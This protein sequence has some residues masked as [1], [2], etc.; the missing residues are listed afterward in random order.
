MCEALSTWPC[1]SASGCHKCGYEKLKRM[2]VCDLALIALGAK[3]QI[4][5]MSDWLEPKTIDLS[6]IQPCT[7]N[8]TQ[9]YR[10]MAGSWIMKDLA[11]QGRSRKWPN[12]GED[13]TKVKKPSTRWLRT[14]HMNTKEEEEEWREPRGN[15]FK[16]FSVQCVCSLAYR[17]SLARSF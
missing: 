3:H 1:T 9:I 14:L 5:Q 12:S 6:N 4:Y 16:D 8:L 10:K 17:D 15:P 11:S 2:S 13:K 7:V